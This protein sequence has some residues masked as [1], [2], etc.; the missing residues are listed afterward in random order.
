MDENELLERIAQLEFENDQ[1]LS[2]MQDVDR[3]LRKVGFIDG[4]QSLKDA[5]RELA[6]S[7]PPDDTSSL[8]E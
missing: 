5:A 2:E 1:L 6:D 4:L 3:L 7:F 8:E